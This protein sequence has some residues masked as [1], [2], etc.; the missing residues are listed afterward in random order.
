MHPCVTSLSLACLWPL[1]ITHWLPTFTLSRETVQLRKT[2]VEL[3]TV[4]SVRECWGGHD[5]LAR[6]DFLC[7]LSFFLP[8]SLSFLFPSFFSLFF[9]NVPGTTAATSCVAGEDLDWSCGESSLW[10]RCCRR[11]HPRL[12]ISLYTPFKSSCGEQSEATVPGGDTGGHFPPTLTRV[13]FRLMV[14]DDGLKLHL[15]DLALI[16]NRSHV[17]SQTSSGLIYLWL[18]CV[19]LNPDLSYF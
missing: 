9:G 5:V 18:L 7:L 10:A 14:L 19:Y 1:T 16:V 2:A 4:R 8:L 12:K 6:Q 13:E 11:I 15:K 17:W 3:L